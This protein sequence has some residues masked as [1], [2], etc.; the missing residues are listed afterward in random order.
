MSNISLFPTYQAPSSKDGIF[1]IINQ[2]WS[3]QRNSTTIGLEVSK[4]GV[5]K[6]SDELQSWNADDYNILLN[7]QLSINNADLLYTS[8]NLA[9][10]CH[11]SVIGVALLWSSPKSFQRGVIEIGVINNQSDLQTLPIKATF[12]AKTFRD[13]VKIEYILYIQE[14]GHPDPKEVIFANKK[15][16]IVGLVDS[17][18]LL[19]DG[20]GSIFP[21]MYVH[22][23]SSA[24]L[25]SLICNW[26]DPYND[27]WMD[28]ISLNFNR[29]NKLFK[30]LDSESK[31][32]F[33]MQ[34][35]REVLSSAMILIVEKLRGE[36]IPVDSL[37]DECAEGSVA[38]VIKYFASVCKCEFR[39]P[40]STS[41]SIR[42]YIEKSMKKQ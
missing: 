35:L 31:V 40:L 3:F 10:A 4:E 36:G 25:W 21:S 34:L 11:D 28:C 42:S 17:Q 12:P 20:T 5:I 27:Q 18:V 30:Y 24:P 39:D 6:S 2:S 32:D 8:G 7:A 19:I 41:E 1:N 33:D 14:P 16:C 22:A 15:G 29:D 38:S 23:G 9:I 37:D 26:E 13:L